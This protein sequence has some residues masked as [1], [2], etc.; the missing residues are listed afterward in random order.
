VGAK[1]V[2][3]AIAPEEGHVLS[4]RVEYLRGFLDKWKY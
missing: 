1:N 3:E 4:E 2:F